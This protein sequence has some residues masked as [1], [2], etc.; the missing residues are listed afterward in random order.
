M[1]CY[2]F[3]KT[4]LNYLGS[5]VIL[6]IS[7]FKVNKNTQFLYQKNIAEKKDQI[8]EACVMT[9]SEKPMCYN[10]FAILKLFPLDLSY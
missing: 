10:T 6:L 4:V 5:M 3:I 9:I 2:E 7:V 8:T 1:K